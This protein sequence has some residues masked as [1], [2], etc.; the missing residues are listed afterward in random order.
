MQNLLGGGQNNLLLNINYTVTCLEVAFT[1]VLRELLLRGVFRGSASPAGMNVKLGRHIYLYISTPVNGDSVL[2]PNCR[3]L[4]FETAQLSFRNNQHNELFYFSDIH[5][6]EIYCLYW[7]YSN[8]K[9][10]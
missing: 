6:H 7:I 2:T 9:K 1:I 3:K 5:E 8:N 10:V 4:E